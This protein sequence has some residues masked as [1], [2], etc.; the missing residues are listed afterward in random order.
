[1]TD[2]LYCCFCG[3]EL[4]PKN[5]IEND[6]PIRARCPNTKCT[7]CMWSFPWEIW[8]ALIEGKNAQDALKRIETNIKGA[9]ATG[10]NVSLYSECKVDGMLDELWNA[11]KEID[12]IIKGE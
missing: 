4:T 6:T 3:A 2:K 10:C 12:S 9:I 5:D 1:M 11:E 8:Q 7:W